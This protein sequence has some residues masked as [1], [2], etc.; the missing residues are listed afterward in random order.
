MGRGNGYCPLPRRG[1]GL[2]E[3]ECEASLAPTLPPPS[4]RGRGD[5]Q[6]AKLGSNRL[7]NALQ[8]PEDVVVPEPQDAESLLPEPSISVGVL[9]AMLAPRMLTTIELDDESTLE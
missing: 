6:G 8:V 2:G 5:A 7:E 9:Q 1:R 4:R 3:G